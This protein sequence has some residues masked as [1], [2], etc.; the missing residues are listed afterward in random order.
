MAK[1]IYNN[2]ITRD[3]DWGGDASTGGAPVSG[4]RVQEY[5]KE[6]IT[7]LDEGKADKSMFVVISDTQYE[8]LAEKDDNVFYYIYED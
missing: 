5:I 7:T 2:K 4:T 6:E 1:P 8:A 3:T